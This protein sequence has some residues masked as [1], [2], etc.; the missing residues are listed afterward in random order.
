MVMGTFCQNIVFLVIYT[1]KSEATAYLVCVFAKQEW[2]AQGCL[3]GFD[4]NIRMPHWL[5][6]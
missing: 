2:K 1:V 3:V 5:E 6:L 4:Y